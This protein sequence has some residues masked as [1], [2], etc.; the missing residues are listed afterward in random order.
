MVGGCAQAS[1]KASCKPAGGGAQVSRRASRGGTAIRS[2]KATPR[3]ELLKVL[4]G[5]S[6]LEVAVMEEEEEQ[7]E[8]GGALRGGEGGSQ[9]I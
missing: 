5:L 2:Q 4:A 7:Q 3:G 9:V 1:A 8:V 6:G